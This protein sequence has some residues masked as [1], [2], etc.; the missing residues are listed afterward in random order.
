MVVFLRPLEPPAVLRRLAQGHRPA[1]GEIRGRG[2][3]N[4]LV[5]PV[6]AHR[7]PAALR[8]LA[9]EPAGSIGLHP[10]DDVRHVLS[11]QAEVGI[12]EIGVLRHEHPHLG[13]RDFVQDSIARGILILQVQR[14]DRIMPC[15]LKHATQAGWQ[16]RVDQKLHAATTCRL[17]SLR[18]C[19]AN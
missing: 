7:E 14:V 11:G 18:D 6:Q 2:E 17:F 3:K 9:Q 4:H 1:T 10:L 12:I 16:M 5:V 15:C 8:R 13:H 19:A